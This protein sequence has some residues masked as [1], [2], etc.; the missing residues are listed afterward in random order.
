MLVAMRTETPKNPFYD[1]RFWRD[2]LRPWQLQH[3]PLC[4]HCLAL[5]LCTAATQVDHIKPISDGGDA[6]DPDNLQSLC[7][8]HHSQKT[9]ADNGGGRSA[10]GGACDASGNP[11]SP[12][13]PWNR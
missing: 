3:Q 5:G 2:R 4:E 6:R 10:S 7:A 12:N 8:S 1:S 9:R 13:H 11:T